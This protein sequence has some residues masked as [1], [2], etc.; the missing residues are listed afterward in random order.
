MRSQRLCFHCIFRPLLYLFRDFE[1]MPRLLSI[2]SIVSRKVDLSQQ[3]KDYVY[4]D[5]KS[6]PHNWN[7]QD[8]RCDSRSRYRIVRTT[9]PVPFSF[10]IGTISTRSQP[11][12]WPLVTLHC[13]TLTSFVDPVQLQ[14]PC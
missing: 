5:H 14:M 3:V 12:N 4:H 9:A 8:V 1:Q 6:C 2:L 11:V 10:N 7:N 13:I